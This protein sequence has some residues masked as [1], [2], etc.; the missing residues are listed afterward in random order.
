MKKRIKFITID[1]WN[2]AIFKL[3]FGEPTFKETKIY[4]VDINNTFSINTTEDEIKEFYKDKNLKDI[5][6]FHGNRIF[7]EPMG[8]SLSFD[9]EIV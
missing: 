2:R 5:L 3:Q 7:T 9:M 8:N 6:V 4:L 1:N